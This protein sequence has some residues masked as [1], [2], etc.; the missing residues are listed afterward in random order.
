M[1]RNRSSSWHFLMQYLM[2]I[3]LRAEHA[4]GAQP[5]MN[6]SS[7]RK[8]G[9]ASASQPPTIGGSSSQA[10]A[11]KQPG[12]AV[13]M[14]A[15][16]SR[17]LPAAAAG[18]SRQ[19]EQLPPIRHSSSQAAAEEIS[20]AEGWKEQGNE[21]FKQ[22]DWAAAREAYSRWARRLGI[23]A[24]LYLV[25]SAFQLLVC[26]PSQPARHDFRSLRQSTTQWGPCRLLV[27][28]PYSLWRLGH[29][30]H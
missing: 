26:M 9:M 5:T 1:N 22:G 25:R 29:R 15:V 7:N 2:S 21:L 12:D 23:S 10:G 20:G 4:Y 14:S 6:G 11:G 16:S 17:R 3:C 18:R 19:P 28:S 27:L 24:V 13:G 8:P 30:P